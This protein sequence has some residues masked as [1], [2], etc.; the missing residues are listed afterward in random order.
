MY[1]FLI[2]R[3][4]ICQMNKNTFNFKKFEIT[5]GNDQLLEVCL[6]PEEV[7]DFFNYV[8]EQAA[9]DYRVE[10]FDE[11]DLLLDTWFLPDIISGN[12]KYDLEKQE[13]KDQTK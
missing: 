13:R 3:D 11:N 10:G 6:T 9:E 7:E 5:D 12:F 2:F 8:N 4:N 1:T